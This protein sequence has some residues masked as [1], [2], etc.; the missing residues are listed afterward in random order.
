LKLSYVPQNDKGGGESPV[1]TGW[2]I[3]ANAKA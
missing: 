2:D 3:P 1:V